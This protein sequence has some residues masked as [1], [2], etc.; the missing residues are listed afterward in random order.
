MRIAFAGRK[1]DLPYPL[2]LPQ[3][4][5]KILGKGHA[6]GIVRTISLR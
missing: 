6:Q 1:K 3:F 5:A 4:R 2:W